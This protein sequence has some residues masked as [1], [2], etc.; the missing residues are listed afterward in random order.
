MDMKSTPSI[1]DLV[2]AASMFPEAGGGYEG[3]VVETSGLWEV[4]RID[5]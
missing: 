1:P 5:R 3:I 4:F 2:Q